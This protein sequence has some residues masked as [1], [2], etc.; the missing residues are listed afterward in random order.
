MMNKELSK[1][2]FTSAFLI[3]LLGLAFFFSYILIISLIIISVIA[4]IE[5]YSLITKI[6]TKN[7]FKIHTL[8]MVSLV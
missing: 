8:R 5:F 6:F 3:I 4:W 7:T 1:R 2:I